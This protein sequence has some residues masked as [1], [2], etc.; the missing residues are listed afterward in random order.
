MPYVKKNCPYF[1]ADLSGEDIK[2]LRDSLMSSP[3]NRN[4]FK[5]YNVVL[6]LLDKLKFDE[7]LAQM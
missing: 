2:L 4:S 6:A 5:D 7:D 3:L 1:V